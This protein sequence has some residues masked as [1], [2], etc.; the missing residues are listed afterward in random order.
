MHEFMGTGKHSK[1]EKPSKKK[2]KNPD[3]KGFF[4]RLKE[5][6]LKM[7]KAKRAIIIVLCSI[8]LIIA[9][10]I[11]LVL[12]FI[13]DIK[14]EYNH[15]EI[16]D[17]DITAIE[18]IDPQVINIALFGID[19]RTVGS[20]TG[21]SDSIMILSVNTGTGDIKLISVMRDSLVE[22]PG[23]SKPY[24]INTAYSLGGPE[25]A[26][27]TLNHNFNLDIKEYATVNFYGMA[28]II[29]AVGGIEVDVREAERTAKNG[30]NANITEQCKY[31]KKNASDYYVSKSGKQTLNGVQAVAW[32]RI[33]SVSTSEGTA[34]DYGRTD[35]Q[36]YVMEQLLNKALSLSVT[37]YPALVKKILPHM[38]TSVSFDEAVSLAVN[39]LGNKV[40]FE[41]TRVPQAKY[42]INDNFYVSYAGSTVY[43]DLDYAAEVIHGIIYGGLT[44]DEYMDKYGVKKNGWY[45]GSASAGGSGGTTSS[46]SSS[47]DVVSSGETDTS[48]DTSS[49][50]TSG[51]ETSSGDTPS[52][53]TSSGDTSSSDTPSSDAP[54]D[55]SESSS[56]T[57]Q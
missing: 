43:Y 37:E 20:F 11:G 51:D 49:D 3:K 23:K 48:G 40:Q 18:P 35:R 5:G 24:K 6:F 53:D 1:P 34:N 17:P 21:L 15:R 31:L 29:D 4:T 42:V 27:K 39:V 9:I 22:I 16:S 19:A 41:Q 25:L 38:E 47:S 14:R 30:L 50:I 57:V 56:E 44:Q 7:S 55:S 10:L 33:R 52:T 2:T 12:G 32:A 28:D 8:M 36:R 26:I 46:D 54:S 45:T 13:A